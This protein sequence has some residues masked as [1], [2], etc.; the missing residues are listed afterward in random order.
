MKKD[1]IWN[2]IGVLAQNAIS[3]LLLIVVT[4]LNGISDSGLFSFAFSV[5]IIFW[6][7][8]MWGGRTYQ[9]S[10]VKKEYSNR[11]YIM[12]RLLLGVA[13]FVGSAIF[14][15][16][17]NYDLLKTSLIF[18]LV[19]FKV[20]ESI[21]DSIY[22]IMQAHDRL[23]STGKSLLYK[24][25]GSLA[26]F[27]IIDLVTQNVLI[28]SLGIII[29]NCLVVAFYDIPVARKLEVIKFPKD[30]IRHYIKD[31][32]VI[33]KRCWPIFIVAFLAAFSLNIPRYF[34]DMY[35]PDEIGYFGI[36]AMPITLVV[37]VMTFILQP[38][39]VQLSRLLDNN[40]FTRFKKIVAKLMYITFLVGFSILIA[41]YFV[42]IQVLH[43]VFGVDFN[44][45]RDALSII[46]VGAIANALV[47][48]F[49]NV[50]VIMR[51]FK[52][53]FYILLI[54][55]LLLLTVSISFVKEYGLMGG[56]ELFTIVN[57]LQI[58]LLFIAY[59]MYVNKLEKYAKEN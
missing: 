4:R 36:L 56:V 41:A 47:A 54:T 14:C 10:D 15:I 49:I 22:G 20:I 44:N 43:I 28:S 33:I 38:N 31:A 2:T 13:V 48:I 30:E 45:Y 16:A 40:D 34:I 12:V 59:R 17:N 8:S 24:A 9:V 37:L 3:P 27:S 1:Y 5:A 21:A 6:T 11:S 25:I 19:L 50:F 53:Q 32:I 57:I 51:R 55:N 42:G 52:E 29:V 46:I 7:I 35:H 39:I 58:I 23:Y 26:V 18:A